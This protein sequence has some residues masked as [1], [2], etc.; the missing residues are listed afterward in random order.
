M[1][2]T[3]HKFCNIGLRLL[4]IVKEDNCSGLRILEYFS[5]SLWMACG[6][7]WF[8][9]FLSLLT[10]ANVREQRLGLMAQAEQIARDFILSPERVRRVTRHL[11]LQMSEE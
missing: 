2:N 5:R 4:H 1:N 10:M 3:K 6:C 11:V 8:S 9:T 7:P